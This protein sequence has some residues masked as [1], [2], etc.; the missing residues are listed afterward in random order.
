MSKLGSKVARYIRKRGWTSREHEGGLLHRV[1]DLTV[2]RLR[3]WDWGH[4]VMILVG[5]YD[6]GTWGVPRVRDLWFRPEGG[7]FV[8]TRDYA[9]VRARN[10]GEW[11]IF[12]SQDDGHTIV[13]GYW[14]GPG[15]DGHIHRTGID[16]RAERRL[17]LRWL[18]WDGLVKA[19]WFGL[20]RWL[21]FKALHAAIYAQAPFTCGAPVPHGGGGYG[22]WHCELRGRHDAHRF[23]SYTWT[24]GGR[25]EYSPL[26]VSRG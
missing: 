17:F 4:R 5:R 18:L 3:W 16:G 19:E 11:R 6:T 15:S 25:A 12:D 26:E 24:D 1:H 14:P 9:R 23:R 10:D 22:H 20:R 7:K 13:I 21:Y 8:T 2:R